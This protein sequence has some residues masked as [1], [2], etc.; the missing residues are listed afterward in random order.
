MSLSLFAAETLVLD[1]LNGRVL[2]SALHR[3]VVLAVETRLMNGL[4]PVLDETLCTEMEDHATAPPPW[5]SE[6]VLRA[7]QERGRIL[8]SLS[9]TMRTLQ[10]A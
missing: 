7:A 9:G 8:R 2:P 3:A 4:M 6:S 1:Y 10:S 5:S